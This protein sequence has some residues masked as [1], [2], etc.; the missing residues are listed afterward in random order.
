MSWTLRLYFWVLRKFND[1]MP[2]RREIKWALDNR[3]YT[4]RIHMALRYYSCGYSID[5]IATLTLSTRERVRQYILKG[6]A[7]ARLAKSKIEPSQPD[8]AA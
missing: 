5:G 2:S 8:D 7:T 4:P 1:N 6:A 3:R